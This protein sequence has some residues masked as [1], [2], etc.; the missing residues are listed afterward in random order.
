MENKKKLIIGSS[1][2]IFAI[3]V[4]V[5]ILSSIEDTSVSNVSNKDYSVEG[6]SLDTDYDLDQGQLS[7]LPDKCIG[8]GKC[9]RID[10]EHFRMNSRV[11]EVVSQNNLDSPKLASAISNCPANSIKFY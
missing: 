9:A 11:A 8:C 1:L 5:I 4:A 2:A 3:F 7:V 6:G 10:S